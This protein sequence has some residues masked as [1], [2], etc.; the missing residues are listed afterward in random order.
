MRTFWMR[1][2]A[3]AYWLLVAD[4]LYILVGII[5]P[6]MAEQP[7]VAA[8]LPLIAVFLG[9]F[10]VVAL[11]TSLWVGTTRRGWVWLVGL[12]PPILFLLLNLPFLPFALTHPTDVP[13]FTAILPLVVGTIVLAI[14]GWR[15]FR[16]ARTSELA[17]PPRRGTLLALTATAGALAAA[18]GTSFLTGI[19]GT[20]G[21]S[22]AE[23]TT[24]ATVEAKDTKFGT[25]ALA[26]RTGETLGVVLINRDPFQHSFDV[27]ALNIH[28]QLPANST[29]VAAVAPT[30]AGP[31]EFYCAVPGHKEAG[32]VGTISV[33]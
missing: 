19:G 24:T 27:D 6:S 8:F 29:S 25:T 1:V 17:L 11:T 13:G 18:L 16:D 28:V 15:S 31:L 7:E 20:T 23:A 2:Y 21:G 22:V 9:L 14:A 5:L 30:A 4:F 32:M 33:E 3:V 10:L 12:V 26:A